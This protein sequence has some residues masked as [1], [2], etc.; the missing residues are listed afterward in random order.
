MAGGDLKIGEVTFFKTKV[1]KGQTLTATVAMQKP[2]HH[3]SN[4]DIES[5][6]VLTVYDD[7]QVQIAN[8]AIKISKNP[9]DANSLTLSWPVT[10]DG[11]AYVSVSCE[12]TGGSI[13]PKEFEPKPGRI[14]LRI[15]EDEA[16]VKP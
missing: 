2:W 5:T 4:Y 12:N 16:G 1:S 14:A 3:G 13:Y 11:S 9:P 15:T 10:L 7:D 6:Y 8:K